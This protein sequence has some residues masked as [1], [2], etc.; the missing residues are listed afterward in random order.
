[1]SAPIRWGV[2]STAS[3]NEKMLAGA[4]LAKD[5]DVV[6]VASRDVDRADTFAA[7]WGIGR[8]YGSYDALLADDTIDAVYVPLPNRMH[9]QWT[10]RALR[11]AKHV[12]CEKPY[13]RQP[14]EVEEAFGEAAAR[15]LVLSEGF[16][17]R[18]HPQISELAR[19]IAD[20]DLIGEVRL[21]VSSFT[22]MT[23]SSDDVRLNASL[24]GR[25][26]VMTRRLDPDLHDAVIG[27]HPPDLSND[28]I[29]RC[30]SH[31]ELDRA[32]AAGARW[33]RSPTARPTSCRHQQR[34]RQ[35][36]R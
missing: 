18:Y 24:D 34:P 3:I 8:A 23:E 28:L 16:M 32:R 15:G 22:W 35:W 4:A 31:C 1:M 20:E 2:L 33:R 17:Y 27:Q 19:I 10:L 29:E 36:T 11:A 5:V 9:H 6:A 7:R 26:V 13:S 12:L 30:S 25:P 21:V 14:V